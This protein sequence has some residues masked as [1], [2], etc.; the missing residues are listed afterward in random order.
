M[1]QSL[2]DLKATIATPPGGDEPKKV[3]NKMRGDWNQ[4]LSYLD[5]KGVRGNPALDKG[6]IGYQMFDNYV[7]DNPGTSLSRETLPVIRGEM[8][9]YRNWV[10]GES[11]KGIK[12][13]AALGEGVNE[14]NFMR[15]IVENE[16]SATPDYPGS[17][18][19]GTSFAS[20]YLNS[21]MN[22]QLIKKE[23]KGFAA[24]AKN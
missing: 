2:A 6:G 13:K 1:A 20:S 14:N 11:K 3:D 22:N 21:F 15:H 4:F 24:V 16:K 9:N 18:M 5:K 12:G 17:Q 8:N 23:N 19:T 7:K 10:L